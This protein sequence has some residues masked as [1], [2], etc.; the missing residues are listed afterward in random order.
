[1]SN[2]P[3]KPT[4]PLLPLPLPVIDLRPLPLT[5]F[6]IRQLWELPVIDFAAL[7]PVKRQAEEARRRALL[8]QAAK[9]AEQ[10]A[11]PVG[12]R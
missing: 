5:R 8:A 2:K 6:T 9:L 10:P 7:D 12:P 3:T 1:M 11:S 4:N